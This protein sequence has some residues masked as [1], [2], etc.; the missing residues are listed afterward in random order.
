MTFGKKKRT[1]AQWE[2]VD[3]KVIQTIIETQPDAEQAAQLI[4]EYTSLT[5][6]LTNRN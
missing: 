2:V 3:K 1:P 5:R 6:N 4:H